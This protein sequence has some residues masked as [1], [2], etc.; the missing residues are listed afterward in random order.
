MSGE[1][2]PTDGQ[3]RAA[4]ISTM[5]SKRWLRDL[6]CVERPHGIDRARPPGNPL[7]PKPVDPDPSKNSELNDRAAHTACDLILRDEQ[8]PWTS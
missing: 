7:V 5:V 2:G 1:A 8:R 4:V 6:N 3:D